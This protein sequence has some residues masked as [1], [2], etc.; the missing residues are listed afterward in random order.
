MA[1]IW[2]LYLGRFESK[3]KNFLRL[4]HLWVDATAA[5]LDRLLCSLVLMKKPRKGGLPPVRHDPVKKG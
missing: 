1:A 5:A 4:S 2:H 3:W